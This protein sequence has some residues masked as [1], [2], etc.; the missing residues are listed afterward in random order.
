[1]PNTGKGHHPRCGGSAGKQAIFRQ[2]F[3]AKTPALSL[4][5]TC[6]TEK[7]GEGVTSSAGRL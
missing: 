5:R 4:G 7:T 6:E 1:M 3:E 2:G